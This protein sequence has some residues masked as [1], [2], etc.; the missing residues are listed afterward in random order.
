MES[1]PLAQPEDRDA[2]FQNT[3]SCERKRQKHKRSQ[4]VF[5]MLCSPGVTLGG[6][7]D[8]G[9]GLCVIFRCLFLINAFCFSIIAGLQCS[10]SFR[11]YSKVTQS[12]IHIYILFLPLSSIMLYHK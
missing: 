1:V 7:G 11:L 6:G 12:H 3:L 5:P 4:Q 9:E 8:E 10:V 2:Q